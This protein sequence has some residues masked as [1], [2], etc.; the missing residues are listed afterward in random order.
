[1][2]INGANLCMDGL[3]QITRWSAKRNNIEDLVI[4]Y[5]SLSITLHKGG[6]FTM[7]SAKRCLFFRL[8]KLHPGECLFRFLVESSFFLHTPSAREPSVVFETVLI[9]LVIILDLPFPL[10]M[11]WVATFFWK[12]YQA[13]LYLIFITNRFH[14][15]NKPLAKDMLSLRLCTDLPIQQKPGYLDFCEMYVFP[16]VRLYCKHI[17]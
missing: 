9:F 10:Q 1:M 8:I 17:F 2:L 7:N 11:F 12:T 13:S 3:V 16:V 15:A 5:T 6:K 4:I 14:D